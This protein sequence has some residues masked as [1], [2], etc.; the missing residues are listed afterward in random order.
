MDK[1]LGNKKAVMLFTLPS[2]LLFGG[3]LLVSGVFS[4]YYSTLEW[5]GIGEGVFIGLD[6]YIEMFRNTIFDKAI[7]NSFL[8]CVFTLAIQLPLALILALILASHIKG[9]VFFRTVFFIPVTLSTV[10]VGQLWLKIYNPNYG[11]LN[12]LLKM[13]GLEQF[14]QNWLGDVNTALFS[15]F[16]PIIWQ[17]IGYHMLLMYTAIKSIPKDIHESAQIDGATGVKAAFKITI[18]LILPT[19]KTCAIFVITGSLKAFDMIY[20]LTNG[21][22]VNSTEVPSSVMFNSIFVINRYGYGSAMAIFIVVECIAIAFILQRFV[23]TSPIE[24]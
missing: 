15:A 20:V 8:L 21:G 1:F 18:P 3:L 16:V 12:E 24:Y 5:N 10:V 9:E 6:N 14:T 4:F 7:L 23:K 13:I 2:L 17:N 19:I 22:P 11:V